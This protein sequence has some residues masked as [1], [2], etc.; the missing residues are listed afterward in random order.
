[1]LQK[2][3]GEMSMGPVASEV[4]L[5]SSNRQFFSSVVSENGRGKEIFAGEGM[6]NSLGVGS[7]VESVEEL[8]DSGKGD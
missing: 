4:V 3:Q 5:G 8:K 1:M 2:E 6:L 7:K